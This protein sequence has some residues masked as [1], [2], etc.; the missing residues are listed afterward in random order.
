MLLSS[1]AAIHYWSKHLDA[2]E[3]SGVAAHTLLASESDGDLKEEDLL[4]A[5]TQ[6]GVFRA[7][8][9]SRLLQMLGRPVGAWQP[10][11]LALPLF[12]LGAASEQTLDSVVPAPLVYRNEVPPLFL[13]EKTSEKVDDLDKEHISDDLRADFDRHLATLSPVATI[14]AAERGQ[15]WLVRGVDDQVLVTIRQ[16]DAEHLLVY[17]GLLTPVDV[18]C[19]CCRR[20]SRPRWIRLISPKICA[21]SLTG[22][23]SSHRTASYSLSPSPGCTGTFSTNMTCPSMKYGALVSGWSS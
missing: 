13:I 4:Y 3:R 11:N 15:R 9:G 5:G 10:S 16:L 22:W 6:A 12:E 20:S 8:S 7:E 19:R 18:P 21:R 2:R 17:Q 23:V 1:L 14:K